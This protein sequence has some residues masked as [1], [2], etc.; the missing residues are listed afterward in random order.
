MRIAAILHEDGGTL[1]TEDLDWFSGVLSPV[2]NAKLSSDLLV[3]KWRQNPDLRA[4]T[5]ETVTLRFSKKRRRDHA[6]LDGE[7]V[8]I[9]DVVELKR[10][11]GA[12]KVLGSARGL[13][14][15]NGV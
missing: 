15:N 12:V 11:K 6:L 13:H 1:K 5:A 14:S 7:L 2:Q 9:E 4:D 10:H 8:L 3:G